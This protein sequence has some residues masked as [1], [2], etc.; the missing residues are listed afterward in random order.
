MS[1]TEQ[2]PERS[3]LWLAAIPVVIFTMMALLFWKGLSGNPSELPSAL[4][5]KPVPEF[6]LP[7]IEGL[8][9][10]GFDTSALKQG[11]VTLVN[12][13]ASWCGPCRIEHPV[14][15]ELSKRGDLRLYG[16]NY[17]DDPANALRFLETLGQ[18]YAAAGA[19]VPGRA[20]VDWGVYGV[21]E[22]FVIDGQG[23]I[24]F[25][26]VGPLSPEAVA[27]MLNPEIEKARTPLAASGS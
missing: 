19:D 15:M 17:K 6:N 22:T 10:P 27:A 26:F 13:W 3:R 16:L 7:A 1:T 24:R 12:V 20:A 9:L 14:L 11:Q 25:K 5:G 4:I 23:I 21:P 8:G 2:P 18:P